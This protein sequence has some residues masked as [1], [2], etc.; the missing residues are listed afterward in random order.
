MHTVHVTPVLKGK[1]YIA[2]LKMPSILNQGGG[3]I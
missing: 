1:I 3:G 2:S